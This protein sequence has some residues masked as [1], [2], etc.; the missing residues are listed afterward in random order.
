[1]PLLY[2]LEED[3]IL[4]RCPNAAA[5]LAAGALLIGLAAGGSPARAQ[6][7]FPDVPPTHWAYQAVEDLANAGLVL[8]YPDGRFLGGRTLTR[9]EMAT[10]VKRIVDNLAQ[11]GGADGAGTP[12]GVTPAQLDEIRRLVDELKAELTV[13]GTDLAAVRTQLQSLQEDVQGLKDVTAGQRTELDTLNTARTQVRVDGYIQGRFTRRGT[14]DALRAPENAAQDTTRGITGNRDTFQ[15]RRARVNIRG[16]VGE[17]AAYRIQLDARP[18]PAAGQDFVQ[19]K[20]AYVTV[21]NFGLGSIPLV[22]SAFGIG[23]GKIFT[24]Q[25]LTLGQQVTPFGYYLQYSSSDRETPERYI[26]F[27]DTTSGLFP[28]QD[29]DKGVSLNGLIANRFQYQLG[30]YNGNGVSSNDLGRRKDFIGR[31][32]LAL[33]PNWDLG[34]SGY[35]GEG[36]NTGT[37]LRIAA[38]IAPAPGLPTV[39]PSNTTP[40]VG[41]IGYGIGQVR[42][43]VRSLVG[44]DTQYYFPFGAALKLEYVRGKGGLTGS[45]ANT[46]PSA[47]QPYVDSA[48]V[49]AYYA[50]LSYNL[51]KSTTLALGYDYFCRN[52]D[53]AD[54]GPLSTITTGSGAGAVTRRVSK[55]NFVEERLQVGVL[56]FLERT[57]ACACST[58]CRST[59]RTFPAPTKPFPGP[60]LYRRSPGKVLTGRPD[61]VRKHARNARSFVPPMNTQKVT[62]RSLAAV[63]ATVTLGAA[64]RWPRPAA[65]VRRPARRRAAGHQG[66]GHAAADRPALGAGV[67]PPETGR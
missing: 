53:P 7:K 26:G 9:Y 57:R 44:L 47:L 42:P 29:Y 20:E 36:P 22:G 17:R 59:I 2:P 5:A 8:G 12:A 24:T 46:V 64:A 56:H 34:V 33:A 38:P 31:V 32:G 4:T 65:G 67:Q 30:L 45:N 16:D 39:Q 37:P 41:P 62:R 55:S 18:S 35:D 23:D 48:S 52:T 6:G 1:V 63:L 43:R 19:V 54:S 66:V 15:V 14:D 51:G 61:R 13:I 50:Q 28:N 25:D 49:E 10:I 3:K 21:K 40:P 27:S 11:R 60:A 58:K